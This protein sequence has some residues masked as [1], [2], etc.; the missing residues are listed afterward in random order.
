MSDND[1]LVYDFCG[2]LKSHQF[3]VADQFLQQVGLAWLQENSQRVRDLVI[4]F[5]YY[6]L[7]IIEYL[8]TKGFLPDD[9]AYSLPSVI[10]ELLV[11]PVVQ[12]FE[13]KEVNMTECLL[14]AG[15]LL[16]GITHE[17]GG[18]YITALDV[19]YDQFWGDDC[20][21][22]S[23]QKNDLAWFPRAYAF[24]RYMG[25]KHFHEMS[26]D[27]VIQNSSLE[28]FYAFEYMKPLSAKEIHNY[29]E[30]RKT[31]AMPCF[32]AYSESIKYTIAWEILASEAVL[33]ESFDEY[34][35]R[36]EAIFKYIKISKKDPV[37]DIESFFSPNVFSSLQASEIKHPTLFSRADYAR[38][39]TEVIS[40]YDY[41]IFKTLSEEDK[42]KLDKGFDIY[43]EQRS[44]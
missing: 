28:I 12:D 36:V 17:G 42:L 13:S 22:Q 15:L 40:K 41:D 31:K 8:K 44:S 24:L 2:F 18:V 30:Y 29:F 32:S 34:S 27:E 25:A 10:N 35:S 20:I 9:Y 3:I 7:K 21:L 38:L 33:D 1:Q 39:R 5:E 14:N 16:N 43:D 11:S 6:P 4:E 37:F 26:R 19:A 23:I